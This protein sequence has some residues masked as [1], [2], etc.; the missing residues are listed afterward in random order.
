MSRKGILLRKC[1]QQH[2]KDAEDKD[3]PAKKKTMPSAGLIS[4]MVGEQP[5]NDATEL[6]RAWGKI[7]DSTVLIFFDP[8]A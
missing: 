5:C 1:P 6:C 3:A 2:G 7:R 8:G 4:D